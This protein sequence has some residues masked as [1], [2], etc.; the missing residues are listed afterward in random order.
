MKVKRLAETLPVRLQTDVEKR[1]RLI[2]MAAG[3]TKSDALRMAINHGL[4]AL[5]AGR[6]SLTRAA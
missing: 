3:I 2:A 1:I 6:I 4:P 5:E